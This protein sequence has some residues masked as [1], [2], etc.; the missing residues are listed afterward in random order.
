[1]LHSRVRFAAFVLVIAI[2]AHA[3]DTVRAR[4][5]LPTVRVTATREGPRSP[6]ELPYAITSVRVDSL[7]ALRRLGVD[8]LLFAIPGVALANRQ[9]PA[10]DPRVSI[11]GFGA[12]SAFGVRGVR[13]LQDGVPVTLPDGQT[14]VD[15]LDVEGAARVDVVRGS[16]SSLY[17]N[18]AGGVIDIRTASPSPL[19]IAPSL[20][21]AAGGDSP[22]LSAIGAGGTLGAL[23]YTSS[24][25][26]IVGSGYRDHS[27]QRATRGALRLQL[28]PGA[29]AGTALTLAA[30]ITDVSLSESPG[31]LTR[32][33]FESN[34]RQA[35]GLS[36]RKQAG[37]IVR[38]G[39]LALTA[40]RAIDATTT[41]DAMLYGTTR[42]LANP[43][44]FATVDVDRR[45]GGASLRVSDAREVRSHAVRFGAGADVQWQSDARL[46]QEN[47]IDATAT[48]ALCPQ[49]SALRGALRKDQREL[50][51]SV[52]P[53]L[54]G[55][56]A[57]APS[58]LASAGVRADA[59]HFTV[60]DHLVT[61]TNPDDSGDR[62]LH[63]VSPAV[64]LVWRP[65]GVTSV[66]ANLSSS[67]ETPTTTELGNKPDGS[68]GINPDLQP[69][70]TIA[71]EVGAKGLLAWA[72]VRWDVALFEAR[73]RD[74][75]VPFDIVNGG[76]RRYYRNAGR[77]VRR[78]GELGIEAESGPVAV[79][80]A[81]SYS[82]FRYVDYVVG[83]RS[84]AGHRIPGVPEQAV[85]LTASLRHGPVIVS[86]TADLAG[87]VDVDDANSAQAPGRAIFGAALGASLHAAGARLS[88]VVA[89]LNLGG[90]R[91]V[92]SVNVNATA[93]K[94]YDPAPGRT[95]LVRLAVARE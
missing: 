89:I 71:G 61:A 4:S 70:R 81:Y 94:F 95:L 1:M 54:R 79:R 73:A 65:S 76:G 28:A 62:T 27:D 46:E 88:P 13:V 93:G 12:R 72:P 3:Q 85:A 57:L 64:G 35:D 69:Q 41:L 66:Y 18:A 29:A 84:Y 86:T 34:A 17:G 63:A 58:L 38:Q 14:P 87:P 11:R 91:S 6:L 36:V 59:V 74:E 19:S 22:T 45:S 33:Q 77:T 67:F 47:C 15:V 44:T 48:S 68:A 60:Q 32:A 7:A 10:Q 83:T 26:R 2:P 21:V 52:G 25:T 49:G 24:L 16:A 30:R 90:I 40:S 92:G 8:E 75:L 51:T 82:H 39:D 37:K 55:E 9:N 31:D 23:G 42:T 5:A 56:L 80:G 50:V 53:Y 43:L 78:G 20:R